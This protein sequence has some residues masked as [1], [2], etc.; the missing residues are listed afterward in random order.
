MFVRNNE[1]N[2]TQVAPNINANRFPFNSSMAFQTKKIVNAPYKAGKNLIQK[3][4]FQRN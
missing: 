2:K 3:I 4:E 1:E